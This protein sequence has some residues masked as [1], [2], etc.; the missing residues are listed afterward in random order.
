MDLR[1]GE[2]VEVRALHA[3]DRAYR[4]W[5]A[6]VESV[7]PDRFVTWNWA[8]HRVEGPQGGWIS[9]GSIRAVY[10][11]DRPYNLLEVYGGAGEL[12]EIYINVA[13]PPI[14]RG[15]H[16][17]FVDHELDVTLRPGG[18]PQLVDEDEFEEAA[19]RFSYTPEFQ[20]ACRRAAAEALVI[21][22]GWRPGG[23]PSTERAHPEAEG[24][25]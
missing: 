11:L 3:D 23:L 17:S 5:D 9:R 8:G 24:Q 12:E 16:V 20:A 21:A 14:L 13:S 7:H 19:A 2:Q 18:Q 15:R 1:V 6:V 10:W 22:A 4:W 25:S